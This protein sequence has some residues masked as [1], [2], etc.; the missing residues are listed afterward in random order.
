MAN[1]IWINLF[2]SASQQLKAVAKKRQHLIRSTNLTR[3]YLE[4]FVTVA[5]ACGGAIYPTFQFTERNTL[6]VSTPL[7]QMRRYAPNTAI[8]RT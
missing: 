8:T 2:T 5:I 1:A 3:L 6:T 4:L 7:Y